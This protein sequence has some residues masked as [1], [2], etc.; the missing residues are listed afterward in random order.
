M[1]IA[2]LTVDPGSYAPRRLYEESR[3]LGH[4]V[5]IVEWKDIRVETSEEE[6]C[7]MTTGRHDLGIFDIIIPRSSKNSSATAEHP[8]MR[9]SKHIFDL[10]P[11]FCARRGIFL[12]NGNYFSRGRARGKLAEQVFLS[13]SGLPGI[14]TITL[15]KGTMENEIPFPY[16]LVVKKND[17]SR[18]QGVYRIENFDQIRTLVEKHEA[19]GARCIAQRY[20]PTE[21]DYRVLIL[22][23]GVIG[24]IERRPKEGEWK[25]NVSLGGSAVT[26]DNERFGALSDLAARVASGL[27]I[28]YAGIDILEHDGRLH[29]IEINDLPQF[30]GFEQALPDTNVARNIVEYSVKRHSELH[31]G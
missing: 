11:S 3:L 15:S 6:G 18:G 16:P 21:S 19:L 10:L 25:A 31:D 23:T 13:E 20:L 26:V 22:G 24:A 17:G 29:V 8:A 2:I 5:E 9:S 28:D 30:E 14:P 27:A 12:L 4:E 7:R 1:R